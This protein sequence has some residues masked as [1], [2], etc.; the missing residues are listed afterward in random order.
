MFWQTT[1]A[2]MFGEWQQ[3]QLRS[4][5]DKIIF[6]WYNLSDC[7]SK[8]WNSSSHDDVKV[9]VSTYNAPR[10]NGGGVLGY[11]INQKDFT[12]TLALK[13]DD[14]N[15]LNDLLDEIK[16]K[17]LYQEWK[18]QLNY[19]GSFRSIICN[20]TNISFNR[21][22]SVKDI[23]GNCVI[24]FLSMENFIA[25]DPIAWYE[26]WATAWTIALDINNIGIRCWL[27]IYV[28]FTWYTTSSLVTLN[29]TDKRT[30]V[31]LSQ[32][33]WY[34]FSSWDILVIDWINMEVSVN[35]TKEWYLWPFMELEN[36]SNIANL[37]INWTY[38]ADITYIYYPNYA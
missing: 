19:N 24:D 10:T 31:A 18:L 15:A 7:V 33:V 2:Y 30:W 12:I 20:V 17:M 37:V 26:I 22:R 1:W 35:G 25:E 23:I 11:Y 9:N 4:L 29:R 8:F 38:Q 3:V 34:G 27:N 21:D 14:E 13:A 36:W 28:V 6:N 5:T 32:I 16:S